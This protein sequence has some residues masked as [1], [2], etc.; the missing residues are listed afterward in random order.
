[1]PVIVR[2]AHVFGPKNTYEKIL[3]MGEYDYIRQAAQQAARRRQAK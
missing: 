2:T 1:M 3:Q